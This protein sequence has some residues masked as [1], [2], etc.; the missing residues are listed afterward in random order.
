VAAGGDHSLLYDADCGFCTRSMQRLM[1]LDRRGRLRAV[2]IQ[3]EEGRRLL[4][5]M[6]EQE[7]LASWHL[8]A[9]DGTIRSGGSAAAPLARLLP[10]GGPVARVLA[11]F[12]RLTDRA[13]GWVA[14]HRDWLGRFLAS[15][16]AV[17]LVGCGS[18]VQEGSELTVYLSGPERGADAA[19]WRDVIDGAAL[20]HE[21][22]GG[23]AAGVPIRV[24]ELDDTAA[25]EGA[26]GWTQARVAANARTAT[27]DS[28]AIAYIGELESD[29]TR[30]SVPITNE[31][32]LL[33]LAPT[34][35]AEGLLRDGP[36]SDDVPTGIQASGERTFGALLV[37]GARSVPLPDR[38]FSRRFRAELGR[39]PGPSAAYG[40]EAM[41]LV[42]DSI[43]R[44]SDP[45]DRGSVVDAFLATS[46]R[47]SILGVYS[48]D[49]VGAATIG[50]S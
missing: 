27:E 26:V 42:M 44:A 17:V 40:Y 32:G 41:A 38:E 45:L 21:A 29:A 19:A 30:A 4:A 23:E 6:S 28:T 2:A 36:G 11:R 18:T 39:R 1:R 35:V 49:Q 8:V 50:G 37:R 13:Y 10:A 31:A 22:A 43:E 25:G 7:Q 12:P 9:P 48:V 5:P 47:E 33:Q 3:S 15:L 46:E 14:D 16:L 20:A 34:A 24:V